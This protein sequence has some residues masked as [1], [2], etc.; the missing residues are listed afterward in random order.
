MIT[1]F[2]HAP[3][4]YDG[5]AGKKML[6]KTFSKV[7]LKAIW[8]DNTYRG[9]FVEYAKKVYQCE[10]KIK[11]NAGQQ[12]FKPVKKRW[13]VERTFAWLTRNRRLAKEYEKTPA[14]SEAMVYLASLRLL[15]KNAVT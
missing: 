13:A 5:V 3:N 2:V 8:A 15:L 11:Q 7:T 6:A 12:G 10:V 1:V 4:I 14:S 9:E